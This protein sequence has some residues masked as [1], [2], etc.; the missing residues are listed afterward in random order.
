MELVSLASAR[1][2]GLTHYYTGKPCVSGHIAKRYTGSRKC[3]L[4]SSERN[5]QYVT[6]HDGNE[7][8][9][10]S[11]TKCNTSKPVSEFSKHATGKYGVSAICKSC[12]SV[13]RNN[14]YLNNKD[15]C[16]VMS[17]NW[18]KENAHKKRIYR[19]KRRAAIL[20]AT[21]SWANTKAIET[22]YQ[23][24]E[25]FSK[26]SGIKYEVDHI[27]PLQGKTVSGLHVH[28]NLQVIPTAENRS[29]GN[30]I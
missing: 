27:I 13:Y 8:Q 11:C 21:P 2:L 18:A 24:A 25:E 4:C 17:A 5:K 9:I 22:M 29:K 26:I 3:V 15:H 23:K 1:E 19:A 10:K 6:K 30:R 14:W 7:S 12:K 28:W 20:N 16:L